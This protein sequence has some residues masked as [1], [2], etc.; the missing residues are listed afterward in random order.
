LRK[1]V[2]RLGDRPTD[3]ALHKVRIQAKRL[4]YIAETAAPVVSPAASRGAANRTVKAATELQDVLGELHDAAVNEKWLRDLLAELAP[5]VSKARHQT[6]MSA[7]VVVGQLVGQA[8]QAQQAKREGWSRQWER[9]DDKR[10]RGW[11]A[12][13]YARR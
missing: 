1:A 10:A 5:S 3:D 6:A 2:R 11:A 4:R 7:A 8:R 13:H 12:D 9:L